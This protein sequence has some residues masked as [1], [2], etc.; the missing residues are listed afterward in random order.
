LVFQFDFQNSIRLM[1]APSPATS[2]T[3]HQF[4]LYSV[5]VLERDVHGDVL[6]VWWVLL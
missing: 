4:P 2:T 6:V 5:A 3:A 1:S